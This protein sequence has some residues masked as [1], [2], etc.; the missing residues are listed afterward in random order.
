MP[1]PIKFIYEKQE[2]F[3]DAFH[4]II[5]CEGKNREPDYFRFFD[6]MSSRVKVVPVEC[7]TGS[8]PN[9]LMETA[10]AKEEELKDENNGDDVVWFV[11]DTDRWREQLHDIRNECEHRQHWR[12]APE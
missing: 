4:F 3:R 9:R 8:A 5:I 12:V 2:P 10:V 11:I 7:G 1:K 6:G